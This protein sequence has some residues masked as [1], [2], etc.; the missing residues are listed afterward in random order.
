[1]FNT[2]QTITLL[3]GQ[4]ELS[5]TTGSETITRAR[6]GAVTVSGN[7]ASRVFQVDAVSPRRS[8]D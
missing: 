4:L 1:M 7:S 6:R 3:A 8:R 2:P 5:N